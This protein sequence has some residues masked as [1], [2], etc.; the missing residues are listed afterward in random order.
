MKKIK[1]LDE[2]NVN[3]S[4]FLGRFRRRNPLQ[5]LLVYALVTFV[6]HST[7]FREPVAIAR[8]LFT[9][10]VVFFDKVTYCIVDGVY[11]FG[12]ALSHSPRKIISDLKK[13][14][15]T[16]KN[17][18]EQLSNLKTENDE[19]RK[20][21]SM[22]ER[23]NCNV[24]IARVLR[25]FSNDYIRSFVLDLG[26]ADGISLEDV[27][28]SNDGLIGRIVEVDKNWSKVMLITDTNSNIPVA[29]RAASVTLD[30]ITLAEAASTLP[31]VLAYPAV[32]SEAENGSSVTLAT[33][34]RTNAIAAGD[35][36]NTL[37][38]VR[39]YEDVS[40]KNGDIVETS[41]YGGVFNDK[42]A[43]GKIVEEN[44]VY[45]V[46]PFADFCATEYVGVL[47]KNK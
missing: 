33:V 17:K 6:L 39:V 36:T 1:K 28:I 11:D 26:E 23:V 9:S 25:S 30:P 5:R 18:L 20:M 21:L 35:N 19:L 7:F 8:N 3:P 32:G 24:S 42:I 27:V 31:T 45:C 13:E 16:F 15:L 29:V 34:E 44:G 22:K 12:Y 10:V 37:K 2:F 43:V 4:S 38:I 46:V 41:G 40:I 47:K 14:N